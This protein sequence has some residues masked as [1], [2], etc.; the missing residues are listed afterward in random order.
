MKAM[1]IAWFGEGFVYIDYVGLNNS[2]RKQ[3]KARNKKRKISDSAF[4][5]E[6]YLVRP[7]RRK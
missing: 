1:Q 3:A 5:D 6:R 4:I 7:K 2:K